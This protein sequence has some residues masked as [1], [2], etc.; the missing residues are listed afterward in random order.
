MMKLLLTYLLIF[1]V[2]ALNAQALDK[3]IVASVGGSISSADVTIGFTIGEPIV[4]LVHNDTSVDQGFWAASHILVIPE[5]PEEDLSGI[6][7]YPNPVEE[8]LTIFTNNIKIYGITLF[9][10]DGRRVLK[11]KVELAQL[12]HKIDLSHL[13]KGMYV[14][15]LFIEGDNKGKLFKIIKK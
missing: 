7:V 10:I 6:L 12:E 8:E 14:L 3:V 15:R 11:Q 2:V 1:T 9:A 5:S 13:S 4:G